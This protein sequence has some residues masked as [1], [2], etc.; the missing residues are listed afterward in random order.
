MEKIIVKQIKATTSSGLIIPDN[1]VQDKRGVIVAVG[2]GDLI[3]GK[4][5]PLKVKVGDEVL[6]FPFAGHEI[7]LDGIEYIVLRQSDIIG[8][9]PKKSALIS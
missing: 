6:W 4:L 9:L 3:D 2:D 7:K 5:I 1:V 8:I